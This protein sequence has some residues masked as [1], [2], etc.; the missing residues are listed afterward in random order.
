[1][2][3]PGP[4]IDKSA[5]AHGVPERVRNDRYRASARDRKCDV[6][7]SE[8]TTVLAHIAVAG[9]SGA[10]LK[11]SDDE[12]LFLCQHCHDEMDGRSLPAKD[13]HKARAVWVIQNYLF[14]RLRARRLKWEAKNG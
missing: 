8:G 12:S 7:L 10:G 9:N 3:R 13:Q 5:L 11:P 4:R 1:M 2:K 14:P 6:C